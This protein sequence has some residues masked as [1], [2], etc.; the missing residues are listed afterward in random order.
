MAFVFYL[1]SA[2]F[3]LKYLLFGERRIMRK[4]RAIIID[5][6]PVVLQLLVTY[7]S[8]RGYEVLSFHEPIVCPVFREKR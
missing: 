6:E 4:R 8:K 2:I 7:L 1:N 5:N 3:F